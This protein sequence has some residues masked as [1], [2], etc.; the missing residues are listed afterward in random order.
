MCPSH[1]TAFWNDTTQYRVKLSVAPKNSLD[2][3]LTTMLDAL[4]QCHDLVNLHRPH[5][6]EKDG[7][8]EVMLMLHYW[9]KANP[10]N[11]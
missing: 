1:E 5:L 3:V 9:F 2:W 11:G 6:W 7:D 4:Y 8:K 10:G